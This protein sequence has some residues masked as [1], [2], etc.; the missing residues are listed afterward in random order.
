M[1]TTILGALVVTL[2]LVAGD[3]GRAQVDNPAVVVNGE[4]I[5]RAELTRTGNALS[6]DQRVDDPAKVLAA[7]D[8]ILV[9]QRGRALGYA[10]SDGQFTATTA[11]I[12]QRRGFLSP[13]DLDAA[14]E[15]EHMTVA[16]LRRDLERQMIVSRLR[17]QVAAWSRF[18]DDLRGS[19]I[20]EWRD[21]ALQRAYDTARARTGRLR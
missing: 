3:S 5:N 17:L 8:T 15:R 19:A 7:I 6:S 2:V 9:A 18:V 4:S 10:L 13:A 1:R 20:I 14:L 16:D 11:N 21:D 12:S